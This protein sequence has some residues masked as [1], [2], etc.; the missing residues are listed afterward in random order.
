MSERLD[1]IKQHLAGTPTSPL[2]LLDACHSL[3][4]E[5][6]RMRNLKGVLMELGNRLVVEHGW[7]PADARWQ[8]VP[9]GDHTGLIA[10]LTQQLNDSQ[11]MRELLGALGFD[12][13]IAEE[14][15]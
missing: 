13:P 8:R 2:F 4:E 7:E 9:A 15:E 6:E 1:E 10:G 11:E 3:V 14:D 12:W 5:V